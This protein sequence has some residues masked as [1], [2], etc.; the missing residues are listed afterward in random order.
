M[1]DFEPYILSHGMG[2]LDFLIATPLAR[3]WYD[4]PKPYTLLEYQ[5]VIDHIPLNG[6]RIIDGGCHHGH[7]SLLLLSQRANWITLIDPH[8]PNLDIAEVNIAL[9]GFQ[10]W[11]WI[12][13]QVALWKENGTIHY[14]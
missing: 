13:R 10:D 11:P 5:W 2:E 9:N 1:P 4:P 6:K 7:Y 3:E 12:L 8:P 14:N